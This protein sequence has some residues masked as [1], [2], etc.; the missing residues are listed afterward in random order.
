MK[1]HSYQ[2]D[3]RCVF[4]LQ[5]FDTDQLTDEHII[6]EAINGT[7]LI[8]RGA[9]RE[10]ARQSNRDYENPALNSDLLLPRLLLELKGKRGGAPK[11][12]RHLPPVFRGDV[13]MTAVPMEERLLDFPVELY[14]K[15]FHLLKFQ[16]PGLLAGVDRG[17][18][19]QELTLEFY[20]IGGKGLSDV[21]VMQ[22]RQNGPFAKTIAKIGYCYAAAEKG[23]DAFDGDDVRALL[24]GER[25]DVYNF[26]GNSAS[27]THLTKDT[28]HGLYFR[29]INGYLVVLVDLFASCRTI[30]EGF[31][32]QVVVGKLR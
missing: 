18:E 8:R 21:T 10:H 27:S 2:G 7:L 16:S 31:P 9:C 3:G 23:L 12:L 26:V 20:N 24:R 13:T 14:P 11:D 32:Y 4:C 22:P 25:D 17:A 5:T 29:E 6:P 30:D 15:T 1:R 28:L 19:I